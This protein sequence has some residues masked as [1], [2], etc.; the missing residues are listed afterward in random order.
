MAKPA[1]FL[2]ATD[3]R[4]PLTVAL[5]YALGAELLDTRKRELTDLVSEA[6]KTFGFQSKTTLTGAFDVSTGLLSLALV[7]A[8]AG[9]ILPD[10][11]AGHLATKTWKALAKDAIALVRAVTE[12]DAA[13]DY[14]FE[15]D[16][17][18][19]IL[20][21]HLRNFALARDARQQWI[22]YDSFVRYR[23]ERRHLQRTDTLIRWLIKT[24][25]KRPLYWMKDPIEGPTCAEEALNTIL[26]RACTGLG[27]GQK[28]IILGEPEFRQVRAQY[29]EKAAEWLKLGEK[30]YDSLVQTIPQDLHGSID[31]KWFH[32]RLGKGPPK[33]K[34]W[35]DDMPGITGFY[36]YQTYL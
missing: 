8:T 15:T 5:A 3:S 36:Y 4:L 21:D 9:E 20:R 13:Y 12:Q 28:D 11:W 31:T 30:R 34:K 29:D 7:N 33:I 35:S 32:Q 2:V 25:V 22:G 16:R 10:E 6:A 17:D 18:P 26:F 1:K 23:E 24:V 14:L 19:R 27:F